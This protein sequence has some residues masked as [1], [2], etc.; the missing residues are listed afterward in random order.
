MRAVSYTHLDVYKRQVMI[1]GPANFPV[2]KKEKQNRARDSNMEEWRYIQG[3]LDKICSTGMG[4]ISADD[5]AAIE[6]LPSFPPQAYV[7]SM[8][9][10]TRYLAR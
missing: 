3:L 6:K 8:T 10:S 7:K 2:G 4:G 5:P 9:P 1:A